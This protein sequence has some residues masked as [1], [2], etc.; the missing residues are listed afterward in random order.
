MGT[1]A[2]QQGIDAGQQLPGIEG[3]GQIIV[4]TGIQTLNAIIYIGL[5]GQ[6]Q[7]GRGGAALP[8]PAAD[9]KAIHLRQHQIQ[10]D[11]TKWLQEITP[12]IGQTDTLVYAKVSDIAASNVEY[13]GDSFEFLKQAGYKNFIGFA[14]N[15]SCWVTV[16]EDYMRHGRIL[17]TGNNL[18][19]SAISTRILQDQLGIYFRYLDQD[20]EDLKK[21]L[22]VDPLKITMLKCGTFAAYHRKFGTTIRKMN[23]ESCEI[24]DLLNC[25]L[26]DSFGKGG[27][28]NEWI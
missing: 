23:P 1:L 10:Q 21:I 26:L 12:I 13:S 6:H 17:V 2:A 27:L 5:C 20:Y 25:H 8:H 4:G 3:L 16:K 11:Q 22:G 28:L 15:G 19:N 7:N 24:N 18:I 14:N 9:L